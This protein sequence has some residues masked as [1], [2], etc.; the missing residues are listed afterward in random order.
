MADGEM[1]RKFDK[2]QF[3]YI[4]HGQIIYKKNREDI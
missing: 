3:L 1:S 2:Y 4:L